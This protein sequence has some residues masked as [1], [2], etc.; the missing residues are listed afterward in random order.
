[1]T[2]FGDQCGDAGECDAHGELEALFL[3]GSQDGGQCLGGEWESCGVG[4]CCQFVEAV[5]V[6]AV[7]QVSEC[8]FFQAEAHDKVPQQDGAL[9]REFWWD[10]ATGFDYVWLDSEHSALNPRA[11]EDTMRTCEVAGLIPLV[12]IPEP[13]DG[14]SARRALEAGAEGIIVPMVRSAADVLDLGRQDAPVG[15]EMEVNVDKGAC[16]SVVTASPNPHQAET[17]RTPS[18]KTAPKV[19]PGAIRISRRTRSVSAT[20]KDAATTAPSHSGG[21]VGRT[22][23][24][25]KRARMGRTS[26]V[27]SESAPSDVASGLDDHQPGIAHRLWVTEGTV[28]KHVRSILTKLNL[29]ETGDDHRRVLAE[30]TFLEAR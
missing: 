3:V 10:G 2:R 19:L 8:L 18:R 26:V 25:I 23:S 6:G 5:W 7:A 13:T 9:R 21:V 24:D 28:E 12:R 30:I 4:G 15:L 27:A 20:M 17:T 16:E 1:M 29:A 14:T 11:L 22:N